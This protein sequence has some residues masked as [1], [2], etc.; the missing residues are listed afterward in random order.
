MSDQQ[1]TSSIA[2]V[3]QVFAVLK[4]ATRGQRDAYRWDVHSP[5][6]EDDPD[7]LVMTRLSNS[8]HLFPTQD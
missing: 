3:E 5:T 7:L 6:E 8:S 1:D 4:L 2:D